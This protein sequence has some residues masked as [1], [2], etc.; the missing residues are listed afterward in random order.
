VVP[1]NVSVAIRVATIPMNEIGMAHHLRSRGRK[2]STNS[3]TRSV[4]AR[5]SSGRTAW[6]SIGGFIG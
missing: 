3:T 4:P 1:I 2:R 5:M 6:K